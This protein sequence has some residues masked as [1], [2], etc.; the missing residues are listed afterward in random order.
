MLAIV[1]ALG[2][3]IAYGTSNF[4]GP[5]LGARHT[6]SAVLLTG[7][8]A[9]LA[10]AVA[11]VLGSGQPPPSAHAILFGV[12]A[13]AGNVLGLATFYRAAQLASVSVV[14]AI[15]ATVGTALPVVFGL[16]TGDQLTPLQA[17]GIVVAMAGG[18]LAAQSSADAIVT[19]A[20]VLWALLSAVGFGTLLIALPEAAEGGIAWALLD[21]R[22]AVV[23]LLLAGILVLGLPLRAPT[24]SLPLLAVPGLLLLGGTLMYADASQRGMLSV[25]AVLASLAT[26][27]T[28]TLAFVISKERLSRTQR[29]GIALATL[30]VVLLAV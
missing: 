11:L 2:T 8:L 28:A 5:L 15:G 1:L 29:T 13:G 6:V 20:G 16:A 4:L 19:R 24:R 21:A 22:I 30:G 14:S 18:V 25:V 26:V 3:S 23:V 9:A 27:V 7:Q 10:G 12:I 17:T